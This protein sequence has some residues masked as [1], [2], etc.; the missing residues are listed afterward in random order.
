MRVVAYCRVSTNKEEQLDSLESQQ[1]FFSEYSKRNNYNLVKIYADEGKSGTRMKNR[2]QLLKLMSD[3]NKNLFDI[4]L[5]KDVSRLARNVLD[6]LT[7]IRKLRA[8]GIRVIFVNYDQTD[9]ESSEFMLTMLSAIAQEESANMSKRV[10]FGK[11]INAEKGKVPN[12]VFGYDKIEGD[13]FNLSINEE[14]AEIVNKIFNMYI[15]EEY[16]A[17]KIAS[18]L[19]KYGYKTKRN[20]NWSQ[21]AVTRILT[22][23]IYIGEIINGKEE[24]SDFLTG[25]RQNIDEEK[26]MITKR[27]EYAIVDKEIFTKANAILKE[28][29]DKYKAFGNRKTEKHIFSQLIRCKECNTAFR[30]QV[31]TYK[32]TYVKWIC[33][34]R[35]SKGVDFCPNTVVIDENELLSSITSYFRELLDDKKNITNKIVSEFNK[36]YKNKDDNQ[37]NEKQLETELAK[38]KKAKEKYTEMYVAEIISMDELREKTNTINQEIYSVYDELKLVKNNITKSDLLQNILSETFKD[39]DKIL[40][41]KNVSHTLLARVI[42]RIEVDKDGNVDIFLKMFEEIGEDGTVLLANNHT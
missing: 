22:N 41:D 25:S 2:T 28:R 12:F 17:A 34:G 13:Y 7:S 4:V 39:I 19:N 29:H 3:A 1:Q 42:E 23:R 35:N 6:F 40:H 15:E 8:L 24:V 33:G 14:E 5:I 38:L 16:G 20:C 11:K 30:R 31:R 37:K 32:N 9:S 36:Q 10:K 18:I 26:W 27:P 21:V